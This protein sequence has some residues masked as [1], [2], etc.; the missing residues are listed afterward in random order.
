MYTVWEYLRVLTTATIG[1]FATKQILDELFVAIKK[2]N[3]RAAL[4]NVSNKNT[5]ANIVKISKR[6]RL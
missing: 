1:Q 6:L 3:Q 5:A 2:L 4:C